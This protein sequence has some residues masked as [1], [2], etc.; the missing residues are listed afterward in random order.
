M[1][2]RRFQLLASVGVLLGILFV[3]MGQQLSAQ[4]ATATPRAA[5]QTY[6]LNVNSVNVREKAD[7]NSKVIGGLVRNET[8]CVLSFATGT[9]EWV[10]VDL[11]PTGE[12]LVGYVLAS[13]V[14]TG[15]PTPNAV[16][17]CDAWNVTSSSA[18]VR[19][20]PK[21]DC[22]A[23]GQLSQNTRICATGY[24][25]SY[26]SWMAIVLEGNVYGY[27]DATKMRAVRDETEC[28]GWDVNVPELALYSSPDANS[29]VVRN[30]VLNTR[31]CQTGETEQNA[32]WIRI[33]YQGQNG[34]VETSFLGAALD[35]IE[36]NADTPT[37]TEFVIP[38]ITANEN[39]NVRTQN[40]TNA[41]LVGVLARGETAL[42]QG[43]S[44][45]GW[46]FILLGNGRSGWVSEA[47]IDV[48]GDTSQVPLVDAN[49]TP[50]ANAVA[51]VATQAGASPT[52]NTTPQQPSATTTEQNAISTITPSSAMATVTDTVLVTIPA[53]NPDALVISNP[54]APTPLPAC[55]YYT[56]NVDSAIVRSNP[57]TNGTPLATLRRNTPVCVRGNVPYLENEWFI[58]ELNPSGSSPTQGFMYQPLLIPMTAPTPTTLAQPTQ[59]TSAQA[60]QPVATAQIQGTIVALATASPGVVNG[61][62]TTP[63]IC[64][65]NTSGS[66]GSTSFATPDPNTGV[67]INCA[68]I[69]P[70]PLV[71]TQPTQF[72]SQIV[73]A[74]DVVLTKMRVRN[75]ELNSPQGAAS[76]SI[77]IP[78]DWNPT[79]TN[80]L[81]LNLEYFETANPV[82]SADI[83]DPATQLSIRLDN[84]LISTITLTKANIGVQTLQIPLPASIL[85]NPNRNIHSLEL[86]LD[87]RDHCRN[88]MDAKAFVR[89]DQS[90]M[91]FEYQ[92]FLPLLDLAKYPRPFYNNRLFISET[93]TAWIVLPQNPSQGDLR[94]AASIAA[95][96]GRLTSAELIVR[97]TTVNQLA[98]ADRQGNHLI[99][100]GKVNNNA[101]VRSL[102]ETNKLQTRVSA[103]GVLSFNS[104]NI[105]ND[106]GVIQLIPHPENPKRAIMVVTSETD[107]GLEKAGQALGGSPSI[108]GLGGSLAIITDA[109]PS[110]YTPPGTAL[111]NTLGFTQ[112][113]I[114]EDVVLSGIG[115][116]IFDVTFN[117]PFGNQITND[118]YVEIL[119]NNAQ[120]LT[121][122]QANFAI[123]MNEV[124]IGS[125]TLGLDAPDGQEPETRGGYK[126][127]RVPVPSSS[128]RV[129]T[130]NTLSLIMDV[131]NDFNCEPPSNNAT[132]FTISRDSL[133]YLPR[134]ILDIASYVPLVG[135]FPSPF[136]SSPNLSNVW[137]SLP[138]EPTQ[139][140]LETAVQVL[141]R[142]GADTY[143]EGFIP[144]LQFGP[145]LEG[146][147]AANYNFIVI[148]RPTT[149]EFL[150]QLNPVL[151][152]P[153]V[154]GSDQI[155]QIIDDVSYQ[156]F[157][158]FD[159][160]VLQVVRSPFA[161]DK[162]ILAI[163]GTSPLGQSYASSALLGQ[164]F[165]SS[166][167]LGNVVFASANAVNP[168]DTRLV[169]DVETVLDRVPELATESA[170][171][172]TETERPSILFTVTPGPT[173]TLTPSRTPGTP[174]PATIFLTATLQPTV[175]TPV[176][177]LAP[178]A[179]D[180]LLPDATRTPSWLLGVMA[181][182]GISLV[183][184]GIFAFYRFVFKQ[185]R[186]KPTGQK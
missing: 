132:W 181:V 137:I 96:L 16:R 36:S 31:V 51:Q 109:R 113:G 4:T 145:L 119:Y 73:L 68:T 30:L 99:L 176:P 75:Q 25:G 63:V 106:S 135:L 56:V 40:N 2:K 166:E 18:P 79:G 86:Q 95:G 60:T 87:A 70:T 71:T 150:R 117:V 55:T 91:H 6:H 105:A 14:A 50:Q 47:A 123:Y 112:L 17:Y 52:V 44:G 157:P 57:S 133:L 104:E 171:I 153:F 169:V 175:N 127:L 149:N 43:I 69:T 155:Q 110:I 159:V 78:D 173:F 85:A 115:T 126:V 134:E 124:P 67:V 141:Q 74:Q 7:A 102:Y 185:R 180:E 77:R 156:L 9:T 5:C 130:A 183:L 82:Q 136:N 140:D 32:D 144:E 33:S 42:M 186:K 161:A 34:F 128:V 151:P 29:T 101:L 35:P 125:V 142:L 163:S 83:A 53:S 139:A 3:V 168:V 23:L 182:T 45:D 121:V 129:G 162:V 76:F 28:E 158:G 8:V 174:I 81:Y 120:S 116:Q 48:A 61:A 108:I 146:V 90:F 24:S 27:V 39:K 10:K 80:I 107:T 12:A 20:C 41:P 11:N 58:V 111:E 49:G 131:Q 167:L 148:G 93:E 66:V 94:A 184:M 138:S 65:A 13:T 19:S 1:M 179:A 22:G 114:T 72:A 170:L 177:T 147:N 26:T 178:L 62:T 152:Q 172:L 59:S 103:D 84:Q 100:I 164:R 37:P 160:G 98:E 165:V 21:G 89:A 154:D 97:V 143:G 38:R 122:A 92:E 64:P 88:S 118:G 15:L 54:N 46:Y